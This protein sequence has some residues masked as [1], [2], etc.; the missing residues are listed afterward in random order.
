MIVVVDDQIFD[1]RKQKVMILLSPTDKQNIAT[2]AEGLNSY[3]AFP[4]TADREEVIKWMEAKI[5]L[6]NNEIILEQHE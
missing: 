2:M 5:K 3:A 4:D 1:P 6:I